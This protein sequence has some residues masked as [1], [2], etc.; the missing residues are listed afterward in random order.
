MSDPVSGQAAPG[1]YTPTP[2]P[3][4]YGDPA[5]TGMVGA[6]RH[7][8]TYLPFYAIFGIFLVGLSFL[9]PIDHG[10]STTNAV[11]ASGSVAAGSGAVTAGG[12]AGA[13]ATSAGALT[14]SGATAAGPA[15]ATGGS[16]AATRAGAKA[17]VAVG[18]VASGGSA[19]V[20][21]VHVGQGTT[22]GGFACTP[23]ANQIPYLEYAAPCVDKFSGGNGGATYKGVSA[24]KVLLVRRKY[25]C[26][27][28]CQA[29]NQFATQA[30]AADPAV[31]EAVR[32]VFLDYFN[33][34]FETYG[35]TVV[36]Q[37]FEGNGDSTAEAEGQGK[38]QACAE[39]DQIANEIKAYGE[40]GGGGS[41][42]FSE[43]AADQKMVEFNGGA[44]YDET[45]Y[46]KLDPYVWNG[47]MECERISHQLAEYIGK[48]LAGRKARWAGDPV[49]AGSTRKF[50][51]YVPT[52]DAYQRCTDATE[53]DLKTKYHLDKQERYNYV[54][55]VSRFPDQ[56][57][58]AVV[59]FHAAGVT[60]VVLACDPISPVFLTQDANSQGFFPEWLNIGVALND[61][62]TIPRLWDSAEI[63]GHLFGMSQLGPSD[64]LVGPTSE[65]GILYKH[66]TGKDIPAGTAGDYFGLVGIFNFIQIAGPVLT[67]QNMAVGIHAMPARG[68]AVPGGTIPFAVGWVSYLDGP[69]GTPGAGDHTGVEDG[70]EVYWDNDGTSPYDGKQGTYVATYGGKRFRNNEWPAEEPPVYPPN[71]TQ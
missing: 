13:A 25:P 42:P 6:A 58:Q 34:V 30:G 68:Q 65:P 46:K 50:G 1:V 3:V 27:A 59:Q 64:A 52:N 31:T 29:V 54:L 7:L 45:W 21:E 28:N 22:R 69:E 5:S 17:G 20:G 62:D 71:D 9:P 35:R 18:S 36:I 44:Y 56:A 38:P 40:T 53:T 33:K 37:D 2:Q 26:S 39:A 57:Q 8:A 49:T 55:D 70:R 16:G 14:G 11:A 32:K 51:T 60:T 41:S 67:P 61:F 4:P 23:G 63:T 43:C 15:A 19:G 24:D 47:I 48:R 66:I 10:R 12:D